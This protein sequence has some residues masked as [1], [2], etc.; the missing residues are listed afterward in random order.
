MAISNC[1]LALC[2]R[3]AVCLQSG[4]RGDGGRKRRGHAANGGHHL[5]EHSTR[6]LHPPLTHTHYLLTRAMLSCYVYYVI[7][8][9]TVIMII[10]V[11]HLFCEKYFLSKFL[12]IT[13]MQRETS[14]LIHVTIKVS[15]DLPHDNECTCMRVFMRNGTLHYNDKKNHVRYYVKYDINPQ[16]VHATFIQSTP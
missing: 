2:W 9:D 5:R 13:C 10:L 6:I 4:A 11:L 1:C 8:V 7:Y 14:L 12:F 3:I 16:E 15:C